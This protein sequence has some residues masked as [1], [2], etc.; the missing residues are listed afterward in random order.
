[1]RVSDRGEHVLS[2]HHAAWARATRVLIGRLNAAPVAGSTAS[3][4]HLSLSLLWQEMQLH[5]PALA[6]A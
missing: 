5:A 6:S 1:M 3:K 4:R 2:E